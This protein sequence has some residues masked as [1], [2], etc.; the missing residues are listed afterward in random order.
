[1]KI[2]IFL[3]LFMFIITGCTVNKQT[4]FDTANVNTESHAHALANRVSALSEVTKASVIV[5]GTNAIVGIE[6]AGELSDD[7]LKA[8]K[9]KVE[10]EVLAAD[11]TIKHVAVT[12]APDMFNRITDI[13]GQV[14]D[15]ERPTTYDK[16]FDEIIMK[17]TPKV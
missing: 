6:I 4:D 11:K 13:S 17:L 3:V 14:D 7:K 1:M 8:I 2:K 9:D 16:N 5:N 10:S 12:A 15:G